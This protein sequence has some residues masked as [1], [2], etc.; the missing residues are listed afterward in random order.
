MARSEE[1]VAQRLA[2]RTAELQLL[3]RRVRD[4]AKARVESQQRRADALE[5]QTAAAK[6]ASSHHDNTPRVCVS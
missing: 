2:Q 4:E 6:Q 1:E 5:A 3:Q